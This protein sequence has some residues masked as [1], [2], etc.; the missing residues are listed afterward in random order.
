MTGRSH[1]PPHGCQTVSL[2]IQRG[3]LGCGTTEYG[4][5]LL[6]KREYLLKVAA[7]WHIRRAPLVGTETF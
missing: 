6:R 5:I 4:G 1:S 3:R 7:K 2:L